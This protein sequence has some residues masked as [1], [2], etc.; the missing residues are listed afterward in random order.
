MKRDYRPTRVPFTKETETELD[1]YM[2]LPLDR[3]KDRYRTQQ[4]VID[5]REAQLTAKLDARPLTTHRELLALRRDINALYATLDA[6]SRA[7]AHQV[8]MT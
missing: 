2:T 3:L 7:I 1:T 5:T 8:V 4:H 6:I